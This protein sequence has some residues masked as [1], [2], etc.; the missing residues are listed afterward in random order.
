MTPAIIILA[1][2]AFIAWGVIASK[3]TSARKKEAIADLQVQQDQ[4]P[5]FDIHALVSAEVE[6]LGLRSINGAVGIPASVLL[7]TWKENTNVVDGC[8]SRDLLGF[9]V[10][11]GIDPSEALDGD[12]SLVC[13]ADSLIAEDTSTDEQPHVEDTPERADGQDSE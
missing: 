8:P 10:T 9:V 5:T 4:M 11:K 13:D 3:R 6:D 2:A 1:V 12:V 7:K